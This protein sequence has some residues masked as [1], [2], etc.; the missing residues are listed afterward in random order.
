MLSGIYSDIPIWHLFWHS[1]WLLSTCNY[2]SLDTPRPHK[3]HWCPD[4]PIAKQQ[5]LATKGSGGCEAQGLSRKTG[6][7]RRT[8]MGFCGNQGWS[9]TTSCCL[10]LWDLSMPHLLFQNGKETL[11]HTGKRKIEKWW[12]MAA[13][14][15][16]N[17]GYVDICGGLI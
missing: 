13:G 2:N 16:W 1:I 9:K 17:M 7:G 4:F 3:N 12:K 8:R 5:E 15:D 11:H 14:L 10:G 6:A